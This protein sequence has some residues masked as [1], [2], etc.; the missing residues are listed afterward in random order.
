MQQEAAG[1]R[2]GTSEVV[3][4]SLKGWVFVVNPASGSGSTGKR[5]PKMLQ[6]FKDAAASKSWSDIGDV[7][8]RRVRAPVHTC[9]ACIL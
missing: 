9:C 5:W 7:A 2:A 6:R 8:I 1:A 3:S 4:A